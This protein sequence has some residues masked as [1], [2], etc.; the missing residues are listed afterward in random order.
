MPDRYGSMAIKGV[1]CFL[2]ICYYY[3]INFKPRLILVPVE[4]NQ[5]N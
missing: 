2:S 4:K 5:A 1:S 3:I